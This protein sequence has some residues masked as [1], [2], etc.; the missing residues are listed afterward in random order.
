MPDHECDATF[1]CKKISD[2]TYCVNAYKKERLTFEDF[3]AK[4]SSIM[5]V[6]AFYW[7]GICLMKG[8]FI[9]V[10]QNSILDENT[11]ESLFASPV[12]ISFGLI[13]EKACKSVKS[14]FGYFYRAFGLFM[15]FLGLISIFM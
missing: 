15:T 2:N 9:C 12:L 1:F 13:C 3:L 6:I 4:V 7:L 8:D 11:S 10:I 14:F 5:L